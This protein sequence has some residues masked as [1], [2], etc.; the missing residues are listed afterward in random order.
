MTIGN[1]NKLKLTYELLNVKHFAILDG[2]TIMQALKDGSHVMYI[3]TTG[4]ALQYEAL[5][6]SVG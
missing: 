2:K 4:Q 1:V 5:R 6:C 3:G